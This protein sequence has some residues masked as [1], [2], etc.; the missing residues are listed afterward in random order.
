[1]KNIFGG[2]LTDY[3]K[4][5]SENKLNLSGLVAMHCEINNISQ[6]EGHNKYVDFLC[7]KLQKKFKK[8]PAEMR[9]LAEDNIDLDYPEM[10]KAI[11]KT[12]KAQDKAKK[13][14]TVETE[15]KLEKIQ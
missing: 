10:E 12:L 3:R 15:K 11:A 9:P 13:E 1:M 8:E 5:T 2:K 7:T 14:E 6:E 4:L